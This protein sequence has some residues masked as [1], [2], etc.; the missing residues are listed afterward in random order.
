MFDISH[1]SQFEHKN[2]TDTKPN[3]CHKI[4]MHPEFNIH[5]NYRSYFNRSPN[6]HQSPP[7][8]P[9]QSSSFRSSRPSSFRPHHQAPYRPYYKPPYRPPPRSYQNKFT[10]TTP[11]SVPGNRIDHPRSQFSSPMSSTISSK[12]TIDQI[13]TS[14]LKKRPFEELDHQESIP[15]KISTKSSINDKSSESKPPVSPNS[16]ASSR[17]PSDYVPPEN[18]RKIDLLRE[19]I[20]YDGLSEKPLLKNLCHKL[21]DTIKYEIVSNNVLSTQPSSNATLPIDTTHKSCS[22]SSSSSS[23]SSSVHPFSM[24]SQ[25]EKIQI[26]TDTI[27]SSSSTSKSIL[28][29][30]GLS[31]DNVTSLASALDHEYKT[32][33][34]TNCL[35]GNIFG[36]VVNKNSCKY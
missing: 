29:Q 17:P 25:K 10:P 27:S 31:N 30:S 26:L 18:E 23:S 28:S 36:E 35:C 6:Q 14:Q 16:M 3:I 12:S 33:D 7:Y 15:S 13:P 20:D 19:I 22:E 4:N 1:R 34:E 11:P 9:H 2:Q 5:R 32:N 24:E 21:M 8:R